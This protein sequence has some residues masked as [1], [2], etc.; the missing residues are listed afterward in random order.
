MKLVD[1]FKVENELP[2]VNDLIERLYQ[3]P[4]PLAYTK[5]CPHLSKRYA[6]IPAQSIE[7][8]CIASTILQR[9]CHSILGAHHERYRSTCL[10]LFGV[11]PDLSQENAMKVYLLAHALIFQFS[12]L[13]KCSFRSSYASLIL[14]QLL[15]AK[16]QV[17]VVSAPSKD[18]F[19]VQFK[20]NKV[21]YIYDPLTNPEIIVPFEIYQ[22]E[23]LEI[24]KKPKQEKLPFKFRI[25]KEFSDEFFKKSSELW[26]KIMEECPPSKPE[27]VL[28]DQQFK[29]C[30]RESGISTKDLASKIPPALNIVNNS[31][32][33][34]F[35][36]LR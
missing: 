16:S 14:A 34:R 21:W 9:Q 36:K 31:T 11:D 5:P 33:P 12:N 28:N 4:Q 18:Q 10:N 20:F 7:I 25:T 17:H 2:L 35:E 32:L 13:G 23:I 26:K 15:P 27:E 30:L 8:A 1:L 3:H 24:L 29:I 6:A 22:T 19:V